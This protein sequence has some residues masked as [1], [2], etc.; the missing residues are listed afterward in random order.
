MALLCWRK[1][2]ELG[3]LDSLYLYGFAL[4]KLALISEDP[5][6]FPANTERLAV[7]LNCLREAKNRGSTMAAEVLDY[8]DRNV[9]LLKGDKSA[10]R[11][12]FG[13]L[14]DEFSILNGLY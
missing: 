9:D 11:E 12:L 6:D 1:A 10:R 7:G 13:L 3:D 4:V 5:V 8:L 2:A 14:V